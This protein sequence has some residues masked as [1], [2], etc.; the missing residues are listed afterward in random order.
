MRELR[1]RTHSYGAIEPALSTN[2]VRRSAPPSM[3]AISMRSLAMRC[4]MRPPS[5]TRSSSRLI[6]D[7]T[8]IAPSASRQMPSGTAPLSCAQTR[9]FESA[10]L[11]ASMS[12]AVSRAAIDSPTISV[13]PSPVITAPF[14]NCRSLAA[15]LTRPSGCTSASFAARP[16]GCA[17]RLK[18]K[19]PT[20]ARPAASTTM[21]LQ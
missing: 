8:Q 3:H 20:Y 1:V 11:A 4:E 5:C 16:L 7:A 18:P 21:S 9:R 17:C 10:P 12:K 13:R 19:F 14:G 2:R 6:G 15:T